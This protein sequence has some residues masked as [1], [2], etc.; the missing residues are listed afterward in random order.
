MSTKVATI[1]VYGRTEKGTEKLEFANM[2]YSFSGLSND[3]SVYKA[4]NFIDS[5]ILAMNLT[6]HITSCF[7]IYFRVLSSQ[8]GSGV[9]LVQSTGA[10]VPFARVL[11]HQAV[12]L[13]P[14]SPLVRV[15]QNN[16]ACSGL[17]SFEYSILGK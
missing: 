15:Q 7:A 11:N 3:K 17:I 12:C 16:S 2:S 6:S 1:R 10:G 13:R 8:L 14:Y 9:V 4:V 5:S